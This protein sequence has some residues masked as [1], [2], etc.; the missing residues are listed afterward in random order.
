MIDLTKYFFS[1]SISWFSTLCIFDKTFVKSIFHWKIVDFTKY[2]S[3]TFFILISRKNDLALL[4]S[5]FP[6]H[7]IISYEVEKN[8][9]HDMIR[10]VKHFVFTMLFVKQQLLLSFFQFA[11]FLSR[12]FFPIFIV[13]SLKPLSRTHFFL[14]WSPHH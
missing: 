10:C 9:F 11:I 13:L 3:N 5:L 12:Y 2:L 7:L 14:Q 6:L 8:L 4:A 1:K